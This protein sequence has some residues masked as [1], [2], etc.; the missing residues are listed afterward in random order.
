MRNPLRSLSMR[1]AVLAAVAV[2]VASGSIGVLIHQTTKSRQLFSGRAAAKWDLLQTIDAGRPSDRPGPAPAVPQHLAVEARTSAIPVT[3]YDTSNP[4]EPV[5]WAAQSFHGTIVT[6]RY[7]MA[8][9]KR[10]LQALDRHTF[11][12]A[13]GTVAV[14]VPLAAFGAEFAGRRL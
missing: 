9:E 7:P 10:D 6:A 2:T 4:S 12:A 3:F 1:M 14:L 5:M 13:A 11:Y 8:S